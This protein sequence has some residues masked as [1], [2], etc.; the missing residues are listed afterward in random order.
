MDERRLLDKQELRKTYFI[1]NY[2]TNANTMLDL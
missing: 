2:P 1:Q